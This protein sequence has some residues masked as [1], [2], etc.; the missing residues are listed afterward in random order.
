MAQHR[1]HFIFLSRVIFKETQM[2]CRMVTKCDHMIIVVVRIKYIQ[3]ASKIFLLSSHKSVYK[4]NQSVSI[5]HIKA[6]FV[7]YLDINFF[8][9]KT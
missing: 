8:V 2:S 4:Y 3:K 9:A 5:E 6:D 1:R 7:S